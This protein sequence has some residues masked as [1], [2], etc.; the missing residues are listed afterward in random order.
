MPT[1]TKRRKVEPYHNPLSDIVPETQLDPVMDDRDIVPETQLD[2]VTEMT[3]TP[4]LVSNLSTIILRIMILLQS[5]F[6]E[7]VLLSTI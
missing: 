3:K 4:T 7:G 5:V 6:R 2:A 1:Q